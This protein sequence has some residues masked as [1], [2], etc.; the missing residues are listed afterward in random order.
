[1]RLLVVSQYFWPEDFRINDLV[2]DLSRRGHRIT[3][4]TGKP[5]YPEGKTFP[6]YARQPRKFLSYHGATVLRVPMIARGSGRLRLLLNY[7][8][9]AAGATLYSTRHFRRADF[10]AILVFEPSPVTVGL[11]AIALKK[12]FGWPIAFWVLDQWP[13]TLSAVGVVKAPLLL[14]FV[15]RLVSFIYS[16]CDLMLSPSKSLVARIGNY[17]RGTR[18]EYFPNW[19]EEQYD[20]PAVSPAPEI[21]VSEGSFSVMF[22]GNIGESQ[23]FPTILDAAE[24]LR[25]NGSVR[26]LI[27]GEG[28]MAEWVRAEVERRRLEKKVL[29]LGRFPLQRMPSFYAHADVL[30][31]SLKADPI[32]SMMIPGKVQSY[33]GSG[34][35]I[36]AM[37][38]GEGA[39]VIEDAGAGLTCLPGDSSRLA[40]I[41][42]ELAGMT[43]SERA[44]LGA[45]GAAYARREFNRDTLIARL[46]QWLEGLSADRRREAR[47]N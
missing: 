19:T 38:D 11:P 14:G 29:L 45:A 17:A 30:L 47:E 20:R 27:A 16:R 28:R 43:E 33:L 44:R 18:V 32:F 37:L 4:L 13:E 21:P 24:K 46:E 39:R 42:T 12:R 10:D 5:N 31:V 2:A 26:W 3:V 41:V 35:A 25:E 34:I 8:S 1:L 23:D 22:A 7:A 6:E 9:Y 15:G 40:E 36:I